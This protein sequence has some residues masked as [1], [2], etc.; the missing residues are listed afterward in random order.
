MIVSF[1]EMRRVAT[2]L[3]VGPMA[4]EDVRILPGA[5][6]QGEGRHVV[7]VRSPAYDEQQHSLRAKLSDIRVLLAGSM[8]DAVIIEEGIEGSQTAALTAQGAPQPVVISLAAYTPR[9][10]A[11]GTDTAQFSS[12]DS[13][14]IRCLETLGS[15]LAR[16]GRVLLE[17]VRQSHKG[18]LRQTD[19][20]RKFIE[21][22]DNYWAVE[23]QTRLRSLK[24]IVRARDQERFRG[25]GLDVKS[26]RPPVYWY[27]RLASD[28]DLATVLKMIDLADRK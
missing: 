18:D 13:A 19:N 26:E 22:P 8:G 28:A 14:F 9:E 4:A 5:P 20:P 25:A 27:L 11:S 21:G 24:V 23:V 17:R 7:L 15:D 6:L 2:G 10:S 3:W 1:E 12:G 16:L